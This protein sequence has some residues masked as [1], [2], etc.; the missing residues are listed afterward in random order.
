MINQEE[1]YQLLHK[2]QWPAILNI[3][4]KHKTR[5]AADPLLHQSARMF[6]TEFMKTVDEYPVED[7]AFTGVLEKLYML[8]GG[9]FFSLPSA[10]PIF[11]SYRIKYS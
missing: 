2:K 7:I 8:H 11:Y 6:E 4:Y 5:T 1:V 9:K 3:L 10:S